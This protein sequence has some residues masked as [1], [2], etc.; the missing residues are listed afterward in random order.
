MAFLKDSRREKDTI[1]EGKAQEFAIESERKM[2]SK[3][4]ALQ[5]RIQ[6]I[7]DQISAIK[8]GPD[9]TTQLRK[10]PLPEEPLNSLANNEEEPKGETA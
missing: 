9:Q 3:I 2:M 1:L 10:V 5:G 4:N 7:N 6:D 8:I